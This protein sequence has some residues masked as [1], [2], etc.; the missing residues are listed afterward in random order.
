MTRRPN[1]RPRALIGLVLATVFAIPA[2]AYAQTPAPEPVIDSAPERV[3]YAS[4]VTIKG[5]VDNAAPGEEVRLQQQRGDMEWRTV[6]SK[7]LDED[8]SFRFRR[9][10]V[11]KSTRYRVAHV[12]VS[13]VETYSD[14]VKVRVKPRITLRVRP[15]DIF[16]GRR[17]KLVGRVYPAVDGREM[18]LQQKV[19][20]EWNT[21]Q[22][23]NVADGEYRTKFRA[24]YRGD[25][26][27]RAIFAGD[28]LNEAAKVT[29][30][31]TIYSPELA[32]WYGPGFYGNSTACGKTLT[33]ETLGVAH[34]TLPCGT[35]V[36][37]LYQGRT[38][39]V[40]VIDR[41]PYSD[42]D[43]DLTQETAERLGFSGTDEVGVTR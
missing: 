10:D 40:E 28:D 39:T 35:K 16:Q 36:S 20:G 19:Q 8:N 7:V 9:G 5:H 15:R 3:A 31:L 34:R 29:K 23:V 37:L 43:W 4:T 26:K 18:L 1:G 14:P 13:E 11:R 38:I 2:I 33:T 30:P 42:A 17:V 41:G 27:V 24:R 12:G 25:R 21:I 22:R 32:T 6:A